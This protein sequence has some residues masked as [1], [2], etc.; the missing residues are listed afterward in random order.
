MKLL[1]T[2]VII[3]TLLISMPLTA[4]SKVPLIDI[5]SLTPT[6]FTITRQEIKRVDYLITNRGQSTKKLNLEY[7]GQGIHVELGTG[8]C[9]PGI[10][11]TP[12]QCCV[13]S[14]KFVGK[15]MDKNIKDGPI[16]CNA[17]DNLECYMP[18]PSEILG[19]TLKSY[20]YY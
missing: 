6:E 1:I 16:L 8:L 2:A 18:I 9:G 15:E 13:L 19:V 20:D 3:I 4:F 5:K 10:I 14:L 12:K 17:N 11:L 7:M